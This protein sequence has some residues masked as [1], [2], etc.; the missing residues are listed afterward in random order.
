MMQARPIGNRKTT[1]FWREPCK[2]LA[3]RPANV[4]KDRARPMSTLVDLSAQ[5]NN[6]F[7]ANARIKHQRG[8]NS[9]ASGSSNISPAS[10]LLGFVAAAIAVV[11]VHQAIVYVL[12]MYKF[13]PPAV[14][15]WSMRP[16]PPYDVPQIVNS[17]FWGGLWGALF[18]AIWPQLPG[19]AMWLRGL[20]FGLLVALFSNWMLLP[21]IKGTLLKLPNQA[22][23][24][25]FD[26]TR[27]LATVLILGGFGLTLG[28][29]YG[30]LRNRS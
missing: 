13:L 18:A 23:F 20:I 10:L 30:L 9:M 27:M 1:K 6:L 25:G 12:G 7:S 2:A 14:Q 11:T 19:G 24:A 8:M 21:F 29:V 17:I 28:L 16:V 26:P 5:C 3:F 4:L 15:A 22:F